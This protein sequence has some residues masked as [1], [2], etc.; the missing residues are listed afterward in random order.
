M[1]L[2]FRACNFDEPTLRVQPKTVVAVRWWEH[3]DITV[4]LKTFDAFDGV[5]PGR[6]PFGAAARSPDGRLWFANGTVLQM[7]DPDPSDWEFSSSA[8]AY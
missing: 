5:Q 6:A 3:P 1:G 2:H 4:Q 8:S 7:I